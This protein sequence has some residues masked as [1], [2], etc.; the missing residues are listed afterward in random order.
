MFDVWDG[1]IQF[2]SPGIVSRFVIGVKIVFSLAHSCGFGSVQLNVWANARGGGGFDLASRPQVNL[3][4]SMRGKKPTN[5]SHRSP[6]DFVSR[7]EE[8]S[9]T[10]AAHKRR[11]VFMNWLRNNEGGIAP[12]KRPS[13]GVGIPMSMR[14]G[15]I[16]R[17]VN[18]AFG[19]DGVRKTRTGIEGTGGQSIDG[20]K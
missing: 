20:E 10:G 15:Y 7:I 16:S 8:K 9:T 6:V 4:C 5:T 13:S 2:V 1:Q 19:G 12:T 3:H 18:E 11:L 17:R 14:W